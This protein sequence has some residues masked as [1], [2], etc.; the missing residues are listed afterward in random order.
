M[1]AIPLGDLL[2]ILG[3][4]SFKQLKMLRISSLMNRPNQVKIIRW[5]NQVC[6]T[7]KNMVT[8]FFYIFQGRFDM[9]KK[10]SVLCCI[11]SFWYVTV[12]A[13]P[14][15]VM[16]LAADLS[17]VGVVINGE[18]YLSDPEYE[19]PLLSYILDQ[20][21]VQSDASVTQQ[22]EEGI[23]K[24]MAYATVADGYAHAVSNVGSYR[25]FSVE[26][27]SSISLT[28]DI[29]AI[30]D[31]TTESLGD[32]AS[33]L[34]FSSIDL[35]MLSGEEYIPLVSNTYD[36]FQYDSFDG[37]LLRLVDEQTLDVSYHFKEKFN[38]KLRLQSTLTA[39]AYAD[40][41]APINVPEPAAASMMI[42]GLTV[43]L[44]LVKFRR[45]K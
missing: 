19:E 34:W 14:I 18:N 8:V 4:D 20:S 7:K 44:P 33:A 3:L 9:V 42:I 5:Y 6:P 37:D 45:K 32:Y 24:N 26:D 25:I 17:K 21:G 10:I 30:V 38:G 27:V 43:L 39:D 1:K 16:T 29:N 15:A 12:G 35:A 36:S 28:L 31:L 41:V 22:F 23:S 13:V 11:V 40:F 2:C